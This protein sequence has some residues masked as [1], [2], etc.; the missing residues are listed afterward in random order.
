MGNF[1]WQST[2][3]N[4]GVSDSRPNLLTVTPHSFQCSTPERHLHSASASLWRRMQTVGI[5]P[6]QHLHSRTQALRCACAASKLIFNWQSEFLKHPRLSMVIFVF[7]HFFDINID[8]KLFITI[9]CIFL[10]CFRLF[11]LIGTVLIRSQF[12]F[13]P[14][15]NHVISM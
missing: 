5:D 14:Q 1:L 8:N 3:A 4:N 7:L 11:C 13:S 12:Y 6:D 10:A 2:P 9:V 15:P